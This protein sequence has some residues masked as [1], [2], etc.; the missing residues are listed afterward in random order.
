MINLVTPI[1]DGPLSALSTL[2]HVSGCLPGATVEIRALNRRT[3]VQT[4]VGSGDP[5]VSL[6]PGE[7]LVGGDQLVARQYFT[8]GSGD[9][10]AETP[11]NRAF[12]VAPVPVG[13]V[14]LGPVD[15]LGRLWECGEY[16]WATGAFPGATVEVLWGGTKVP[17]G[18]GV[19]NG[20]AA[21]FRLAQ[22][23][24]ANEIVQVLQRTPSGQGPIVKRQVQPI[25]PEDQNQLRAPVIHPPVRDCHAAVLV[26]GVFE[27][28]EV[29]LTRKSG[30]EDRAGFDLSSLWFILSRPL[31]L[32]DAWISARQEMLRCERKGVSSA[33][34]NIEPATTPRTPIINTHICVGSTRIQVAAL[35]PG[36]EVRITNGSTTVR[37]TAK[38]AL[39]Q[40][41][42]IPPAVPGTVSVTQLLCGM[43]SAAATVPVDPQP[44]SV[45]QPQIETPL[46]RCARTVQVRNAH[47]GA[48]IQIWAKGAALGLR[49]ISAQV[50][51]ATVDVTVNVTPFLLERD[52]VW[53]LEWPCGLEPVASP[54]SPVLALPQ[55]LDP[56]I[57]EPVTRLDTAAIVRRTIKGAAV[58]VLRQRKDLTWEII[59][60]AWATGSSTSV[61]L[62]V[63]LSNDQKLRPRQRI[64]EIERNESPIVTVVKPAPLPPVL[65]AP[66]NGAS[67]PRNT[68]ITLSW[69]DPG[70]SQDRKADA[71]DVM[72]VGGT[73]SPFVP[74]VT[75]LSATV[76]ATQS[77]KFSAN[78]SWTVV[79]RNSTGTASATSTFHTPSAPVPT[80]SAR[81]D[82][83]K[84]KCEGSGF[85]AGHQVEIS[86][87][88]SFSALAGSPSNP[89]QVV[90]NRSGVATT[91]AKADGTI[92]VSLSPEDVLELRTVLEN[93]VLLSYKSAP[94]PGAD[95]T[96][97]ARNAPPISPS[98]GSPNWSADVAFKWN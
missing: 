29:V 23:F 37:G 18:Q 86:I 30:E 79:A 44:V 16:V 2:I 47:L 31:D 32:S 53:A 14:G 15:I 98:D 83:N 68:A 13:S 48:M 61:P 50:V 43:V 11:A 33:P 40:E 90:D 35:E 41:F 4:P 94:F 77:T 76:P 28:A 6:L 96:V 39:V 85:A 60:T 66:P 93:G 3:V 62:M 20:N 57:A 89:I 7:V 91:I 73:T 64:C 78:F 17:K 21:R 54:S 19:A 88:T 22:Q 87:R 75:G 1:I 38:A 8:D 5:W 49:P 81:R 71:F 25:P 70:A 56:S 55:V 12:S 97:R 34:V 26:E 63:T 36:A 69:T 52:D 10:S 27:G 9:E 65:V 51:A 82:G 72:V 58:E 46:Y 95:M 92:D 74:A 45:A 42:D 67:V 24:P 84:I 80:F 59:G